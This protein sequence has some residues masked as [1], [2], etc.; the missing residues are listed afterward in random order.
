MQPRILRLVEFTIGTSSTNSC[1]G[2]PSKALEI[3]KRPPQSTAPVLLE[4]RR[5]R[6][7]LAHLQIAAISEFAAVTSPAI[8]REGPVINIWVSSA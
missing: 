3:L 1:G 6:F 2:P 7:D 8:G 4:F 5:I